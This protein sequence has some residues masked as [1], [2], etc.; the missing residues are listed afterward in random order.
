MSSIKR[1]KFSYKI[2]RAAYGI[3]VKALI[4]TL[5]YT[6]ARYESLSSNTVNRHAI[7][8]I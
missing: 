4:R 1:S 8:W 5:D 2:G 7:Y 3:V 6:R